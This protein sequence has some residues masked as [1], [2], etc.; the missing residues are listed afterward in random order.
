MSS[1]SSAA[2]KSPDGAKSQIVRKYFDDQRRLLR[3][4]LQLLA[5][6]A[7]AQR[8]GPSNPYPLAFG[9]RDLVAHPFADHLPLELGEGQQNVER[10]PSHARGGVEGLGDRDEGDAMFVERLDELGEVGQRAGQ[11][12]DL[13]DDDDVEFL[14]PNLLQQ[15]LQRGALQ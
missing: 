5:D 7:I 9:R 11:P 4:D 13:I 10:Q 8:D 2:A 1:R 6:A 15:H 14:G 3:N 12:V